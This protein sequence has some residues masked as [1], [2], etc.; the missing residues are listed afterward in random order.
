M[1]SSLYIKNGVLIDP[2]LGLRRRAGLF[3]RDGLIERIVSGSCVADQVLDAREAFVCPGFVD[4]HVHLREPGFEHKETI[5]SGLQSAVRGGFT[6]VACM[7]N[8][9]PACDHPRI[10]HFIKERARQTGLA[11]VYPV[12]AITTNLEGGQLT[13]LAGL[14]AAGAKLF[15]NDGRPVELAGTMLEAARA[16]KALAGIILDHCEDR[17]IAGGGV[18][19]QCQL[20]SGWCLPGISPLAEEIHIA[21][22]ILIAED[23]GCP[24]HITHLSTGRGVDLIRWSRRRLAPVTAE[25]TPHHLCLAVE[26]MPAPEPDFKMNPPLR[27]VEDRNALLTG[28][29]DGSIDTIATDH[30]PHT[31]GEKEKGF[32]EAPFG[33]VGFETAIPLLMDQF[34]RPGRLPLEKL[35][36]CCSRHPARLTGAP[37]RSLKPGSRANLTLIHPEIT[38]RVNRQTMASKSSNTPFDGWE[39]QGAVLATIV[40]GRLV[41][42]L[43]P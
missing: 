15:S 36:D 28:L 23:T 11:E 19:H 35:V 39:L 43:N 20:S 18:M 40:D 13:D 21:R 12:C 42:Q 1:S 38:T 33:I 4:M 24:F 9:K 2:A 22:D 10:Y 27:T 34:V 17:S 5:E 7:P 14:A 6:A 31:T 26:N 25:A 16:I 8:T 41:Y 29:L 32:S 3:I 30:A 37:L